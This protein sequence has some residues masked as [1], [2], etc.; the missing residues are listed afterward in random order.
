MKVADL[1]ADLKAMTASEFNQRRL[2]NSQSWYFEPDRLFTLQGNYDDFRAALAG[3]LNV[4]PQNIAIVG[5]AKFGVSLSPR[6]NFKEFGEDSDI[7]VVV[8]SPKWFETIWEHLQT[9]YFNGYEEARK[10][11]AR[12]IFHR[13]VNLQSRHDFNTAYLTEV[14][15]KT[16]EI[17]R[18]VSAPLGIVH[19]IS[20]RVYSD[21]NDVDA[22]HRWSTERLKE[23]IK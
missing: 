4:N 20:Y 1:I 15:K 6:K 3:V 9:A 17:G 7:D 23:T 11:Y 19:P 16:D 2:F 13:Y 5:S 14:I 8:V 10:V 18:S 12:E 21:W 22:Y